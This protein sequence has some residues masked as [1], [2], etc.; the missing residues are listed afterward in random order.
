MIENN[1]DTNKNAL[2][3][4]GKNDLSI[5]GLEALTCL[6][7]FSVQGVIYTHYKNKRVS[8]EFKPLK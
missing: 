7:I 3:E 2:R 5:K 4:R 6:S 8:S 1:K